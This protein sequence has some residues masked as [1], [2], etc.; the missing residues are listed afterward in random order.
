MRRR[1]LA[2]AAS[3]R[4]VAMYILAGMGMCASDFLTFVF[5]HG[6]SEAAAHTQLTFAVCMAMIGVQVRSVFAAVPITLACVAGMVAVPRLAPVFAMTSLA[7]ASVVLVVSFR[8]HA[9]AAQ[10]SLN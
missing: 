7:A 2:T 1:L 6:T 3:R 4:L 9:A 10:P 5:G 8:R